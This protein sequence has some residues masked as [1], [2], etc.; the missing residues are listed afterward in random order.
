[1]KVLY[2][3]CC[4][5]PPTPQPGAAN[6]DEG[7]GVERGEGQENFLEEVILEQRISKIFNKG[8]GMDRHLIKATGYKASR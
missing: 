8:K 4:E 6:L 5:T 1:M 3:K 2:T 7:C